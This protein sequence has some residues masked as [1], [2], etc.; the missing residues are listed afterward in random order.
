MATYAWRK[1]TMEGM[2]ATARVSLHFTRFPKEAADALYD[3]V[4]SGEGDRTKLGRAL[5][6]SPGLLEAHWDCGDKALH[7]ACQGHRID[8]IRWLIELGADPC[9]KRESDRGDTVLHEWLKNCGR[10]DLRASVEMTQYLLEKGAIADDK[11]VLI[12]AHEGPFEVFRLV[13]EQAPRSNA[14][15]TQSLAEASSKGDI[16]I[17]Q[18]LLA[19]GEATNGRAGDGWD[20]STL[21]RAANADVVRTLISAGASPNRFARYGSQETTPLHG[22]CHGKTLDVIAALVEGGADV[23]VR[24]ST[25][26]TPLAEVVAAQREDANEIIEYLIANGAK[27][28]GD[29]G[30]LVAAMDRPQLVRALISKGFDPGE[31]KFQEMPVFRDLNRYHAYE[32]REDGWAPFFN[33]SFSAFLLALGNSREV[34]NHPQ[35]SVLFLKK[36]AAHDTVAFDQLVAKAFPPGSDAS[37]ALPNPSNNYRGF[38]GFAL[39][40]ATANA[41]GAWTG[42]PEESVCKLIAASVTEFKRIGDNELRMFSFLEAFRAREL[43]DDFS[44]GVLLPHII[45]EARDRS[46][47]TST[48]NKE[49]RLHNTVDNKFVRRLR[50]LAAEMLFGGRNVW[51]SLKMVDRWFARRA[52][53]VMANASSVTSGI[54]DF[55]GKNGWERLLKDG[56]V[57]V[58]ERLGVGMQIIE[59]NTHGD[60]TILGE[61]L[62]NCFSHSANP[63]QYVRNGLHLFALRDA[64]GRDVAMFE[65]QKSVSKNECR[66]KFHNGVIKQ[67]SPLG[68]DKRMIVNWFIEE[69]NNR[70]VEADWNANSQEAIDHR[71]LISRIGYVPTPE[72][73]ERAWRTFH[74]SR[75]R[76]PV[77]GSDGLPILDEKASEKNGGAIYRQGHAPFLPT[78]VRK[79]KLAEGIDAAGIRG[80]L[81]ALIQELTSNSR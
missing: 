29:T 36:L 73:V 69:L 27:T 12:A 15:S 49:H 9:A 59:V 55:P 47:D 76:L 74:D 39:M 8:E 46:G 37:R 16:R 7:L 25:G 2:T 44:E 18:F 72:K 75:L 14:L 48:L 78:R 33:L 63:D 40:V 64:E 53:L 41:L 13:Y 80:R 70:R 10:A 1:L 51:D 71:E 22:A 66:V 24:S 34:D 79:Q 28:S 19:E 6:N 3:L 5:K 32:T 21:H 43:V 30:P 11:A 17:V 58:P 38:A 56:Q 52:G 81:E 54:R 65:L 57:A 20:E 67:K 60:A 68:P 42:L 77:V 45:V 23:S 61:A 31:V 26:R 62:E 50:P 35:G 4:S